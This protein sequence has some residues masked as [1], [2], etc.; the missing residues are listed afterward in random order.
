MAVFCV[1]VPSTGGN[2]SG[3]ERGGEAKTNALVGR[4]RGVHRA[5]RRRSD[6]PLAPAGVLRSGATPD[7]RGLDLSA[8]R[9]GGRGDAD[10]VAACCCRSARSDHAATASAAAAPGCDPGAF[11]SSDTL[12]DRPSRR[13]RR[14]RERSPLR[15]RRRCKGP[16][17]AAAAASGGPARRQR[18]TAA[19]PSAFGGVRNRLG[20]TDGAGTGALPGAVRS[21]RRGRPRSPA[22]GLGGSPARRRGATAGPQ[23]A[24]RRQR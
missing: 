6:G 10:A 15:R 14:G 11:H 21:R 19:L 4:L 24:V 16:R 22:E 13:A 5:P 17:Q 9:A 20:A 1:I 7:H 18:R 3:R 12:D 8:L 23:V 2:D